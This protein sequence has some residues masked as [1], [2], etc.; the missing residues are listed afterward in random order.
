MVLPGRTAS[1]S[2]INLEGE[3]ARLYNSTK[4]K[5]VSIAV[6]SVPSRNEGY[7]PPDEESG[8]QVAVGSGFI[9]DSLGHIVTTSSVTRQGN[10]F[11]IT[12]Y[13]GSSR[14]AQMVGTDPE[15]N[16]SVLK[17]THSPF[18]PPLYA[19]SGNVNPGHWVGLLGNAYGV[20]PSF[21]YGTAA[22]FNNNGHI[23]VT[24]DISPGSAGGMIINS[25]GEVVGMMAY[26]LTE[27]VPFDLTLRKSERDLVR[28]DF[29]QGNVDL[30]VGG[31]SLAIPAH[32]ILKSGRKI[33]A[34]QLKPRAFLGVYS[35]NL[36]R[37]WARRMFNI[38]HGVFI[39]EVLSGSPAWRAG[40]REGDILLKFEG[41][42]IMNTTQLKNLI[43]GMSPESEV[44]ASLLRAGKI[45][46]VEIVL[47]A[48]TV[49]GQNYNN[50]SYS[51]P[52]ARDSLR[53]NRPR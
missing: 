24:A 13:D 30:P 17:V 6:S 47:G 42:R 50:Q 34:G 11:R 41:F 38:D 36:D 31:M 40:I 39:S 16:I 9:F 29:H 44:N 25:R 23:L 22:G 5:V 1:Q 51:S 4:D 49:T 35:D 8:Y 43:N 48:L 18:L 19:D 53:G 32:Q 12:Y 3:Y 33:I 37:N 15:L 45:V 10:L 20:F 27:Q 2:I 26:K 7:Y 21:V 14:F 28:S 52:P 46:K